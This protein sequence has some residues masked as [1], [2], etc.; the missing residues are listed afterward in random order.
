MKSF[1]QFLKEKKK[2][3]VVTAQPV[4]GA[5][6]KPKKAFTVTAQPVHGKHSIKEEQKSEGHW[7][8][9]EE[10]RTGLPDTL[11]S[12]YAH[13]KLDSDEKKHLKEYSTSSAGLSSYLIDKH[14]GDSI[15]NHNYDEKAN[16]I[17]RIHD[18]HKLPEAIKTYH[19]TS[20]DPREAGDSDV[21]FPTAISS[22]LNKHVA[23]NFSKAVTNK[24]TGDYERHIITF[25]MPKGSGGYYLGKNS[26]YDEEKE[27]L[28]KPG[29]TFRKVKEPESY[30]GYDGRDTIIHHYAPVEEN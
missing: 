7:S 15:T 8:F 2:A 22:S 5:H 14:K 6:T 1:T 20:F 25:H 26:Q 21:N 3:F 12:H 28:M 27:F 4:H 16:V 18:R 23:R 30:K 10:N 19:G 17:S 11:Q 24:K 29:T 13:D 9:E